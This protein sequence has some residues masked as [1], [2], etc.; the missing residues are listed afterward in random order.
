MDLAR[1]A[2]ENASECL[3]RRRLARLGD[4]H[5]AGVRNWTEGAALAKTGRRILL[6]LR[7]LDRRQYGRTCEGPWRAIGDCGFAPALLLVHG[8]VE[9]RIWRYSN[10]SARGG[11]RLGAASRPRDCVLEG[12]NPSAE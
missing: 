5:R 4:S 2:A 12:R 6:G 11:P 7:Q 8:G 1:G 3:L 9:S 10:L